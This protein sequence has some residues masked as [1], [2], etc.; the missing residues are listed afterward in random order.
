[1][2]IPLFCFILFSCFTKICYIVL[3]TV[4]SDILQSLQLAR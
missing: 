2:K 3:K 1:M 4:N